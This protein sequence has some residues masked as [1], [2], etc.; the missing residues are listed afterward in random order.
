M[1]S[2][3]VVFEQLNRWADRIAFLMGRT[4]GWGY[5][6]CACYITTDVITRRFFGFSSQGTVEISGYLLALGVT[7]GLAAAL[8]HR[9]HIRVDLLVNKMPLGLRAYLHCLALLFLVAYS[10]ILTDRSWAVARES[11]VLGS[12]D[13]S[14]LYTPLAIPQTAWAIGF[15]A[16]AAL[17]LILFARALLLLV[18]RQLG[19]V[20]RLLAPLSLEEGVR[21]ELEA[22]GFSDSKAAAAS[23]GADPR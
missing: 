19:A 17:T 21:E 15:T 23:L 1:K 7:W 12:K 13:T 3:L 4:A 11:F 18:L 20:D 16:F 6:L 22:A 9:S 8:S 10:L 14:A 2:L 5:L